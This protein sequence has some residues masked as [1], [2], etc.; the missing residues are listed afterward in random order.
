MLGPFQTT[1]YTDFS[2]PRN[3][4][5]F[6]AAL[7]LVTRNLGRTWP[8]VIGGV[9]ETLEATFDSVNPGDLDQTIGSFGDG[10]T[11]HADRA[12]SV[13]WAAFPAWAAT[14][15]QDRA[16]ILLRAAEMMRE[17]RHEFSAAMVLEAGK[18]W[19]EADGDTAEAIDF[20][21]FYARSAVEWAAP[22]PTTPY[23][24][25]LNSVHYLPLGVGVAIPPWNFPV[26]IV[27]GMCAA[28]IAAGNTMILK[29]AEQTPY[30]AWL[31]FDLFRQAG[32][33]DGVLN[34]VTCADGAIVGGH[35]VQHPR[36]RF[37]SFTGSR[38]VGCW[39]YEEA[40]K[41]RPGQI[42]LKRVVAEMGGKDAILVDRDAHVEAAAVAIVKSAFGFQGQKCSAGS[43]ALI[44]TAVY[45]KVEARVVELTKQL[46]QGDPRDVANHAGPVIDEEARDKV[47]SYIAIGKSEATLLAGGEAAPGNGHYIQPTVFGSVPE[48]ARIAN[49]EIFG[50]VLALVRVTDYEAGVRIFNDTDYGLTGGFFGTAN[51]EDAKRRLFC[52]NLYI[53]RKCTGALV[54][55]QPFGGFNMS[56]TDAKAGGREHLLQFLQ[57]KSIAERLVPGPY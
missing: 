6:R 55:V 21:D 49:E 9:E 5:A 11:D 20:L 52:G 3:Q 25:E 17:R 43:R 46:V 47:L 12:L 30:T 29:P 53:N 36:T 22:R 10:T 27:A 28:P 45:D 13:A 4:A 18:S 23:P 44:H 15:V 2:D 38:A 7:D 35:L 16:N 14:P 37:I 34:Y 26:A 19:P 48:D 51:I 54:D 50:P 8:V 42:W 32:L 39:I 40:G 1:T 31:V 33:P 56:G 24:G 57:A 41:V